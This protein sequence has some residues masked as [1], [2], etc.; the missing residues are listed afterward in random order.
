MSQELNEM[1]AAFERR[2]FYQL[3]QIL[4]SHHLPDGSSP[5]AVAYSGGLDSTVLVHLVARFAELHDIPWFCVHVHH[6]LS[7]N[8][9]DW[10]R[11]CEQICGGLN[12]ELERAYVVVRP[13]GNGIE[14][15]ARTERYRA[16]G[17]V[18]QRRGAKVVL[19]AHHIDDQAETVLMQLMRGSGV[20]GLAGMELSNMAPKLL[21]CDSLVVVRPLLG[22]TRAQLESYFASKNLS[23]IEDESNQ[24]VRFVRN[25]VRAKVIPEFESISHGFAERVS[26]TARHM[27]EAHLLL[28]ELAAEDLAASRLNDGALSLE[29]I[30]CYSLARRR[31]LFRYWIAS[32][33]V[34]MPSTAKLEEIMRQLTEAKEDARIQVHHDGVMFSRYQDR[35]YAVLET[36]PATTFS[37][38][39]ETSEFVWSGEESVALPGF[40]GRLY[41]KE[42]DFGVAYSKLLGQKLECRHRSAGVRLRLSKNRPSRDMKSH[43][44]AAGIPF[45][46]RDQVPFLYLDAKLLFVGEL[47]LEAAF[48]DESSEKKIQLEWRSD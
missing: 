5:I 30:A 1:I 36:L 33:G 14:A 35:L 32:S 43:F 42:A 38:E 4:K 28:D 18:C 10:L 12:C 25:A 19:T 8:A 24:D 39:L 40:S 37:R 27:R 34:Q 13:N 23:K 20:R 22:E 26:R 9:D 29:R 31:N 7:P 48:L 41:F 3:L 2:F 44:Q 21:G 46:R 16:I 47:G 11:H 17:K 6:G 15:S 45:W